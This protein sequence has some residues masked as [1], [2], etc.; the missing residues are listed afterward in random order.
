MIIELII[1]E[2]EIKYCNTQKCTD[3]NKS[4]WTYL[5][6]IIIQGV[7]FKSRRQCAGLDKSGDL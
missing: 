1:I 7:L 4:Y 6:V 3:P 2:L 5:Y